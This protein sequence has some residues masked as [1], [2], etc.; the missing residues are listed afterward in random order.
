MA[1]DHIRC[2]EEPAALNRSSHHLDDI[3]R[4]GAASQP[5]LRRSIANVEM[6]PDEIRVARR[7][8]GFRK[9]VQRLPEPAAECEAE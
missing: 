7:D 1:I 3:G 4:P 5:G 6:H 8:I 9:I 2:D